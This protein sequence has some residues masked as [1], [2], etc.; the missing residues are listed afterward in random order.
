M[1]L[2]FHSLGRVVPEPVGGLAM[3]PGHQTSQR[4][5]WED[6]ASQ[7]PLWVHRQ[8]GIFQAHLDFG[9]QCVWETRE[10]MTLARQHQPVGPRAAL[11][12]RETPFLLGHL[13]SFL[14]PTSPG[15]RASCGLSFQVS[16]G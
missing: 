12:P 6:Y 1:A 4:L 8:Q 7:V 3:A 13:W 10:P 2:T 14:G 15:P 16:E 11:A 9:T 5:P